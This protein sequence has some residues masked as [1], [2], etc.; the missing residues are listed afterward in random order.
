MMAKK[1][2]VHII[3][4]LDLGGAETALYRMLSTMSPN[5]EFQVIV[6]HG[7]GGYY[8][9]KITALGITV[10]HLNL[11]KNNI[12]KSFYRLTSLIKATQ[13]DLVQTWLYHADLIGGLSAKLCG[14]K[15]I[16]W[17]I[18][19]EG[20]G[21]KKT[22]ML[23][24]KIC[25]LFSWVIPDVIITNSQAA[26]YNHVRTGYNTK[27]IKLIYNGFDSV[28]FLPAKNKTSLI[29]NKKLPTDAI[30][31][32]TL[33]RFHQDK[34][35]LTLIQAIDP[36]CSVHNNVYF[37]FCGRGCNWHNHELT[38]MIAA[39]T[40]QKNIILIDG[41]DNAAHYLSSLDI[42]VLSSKTESFPNSLAEAML[43]GLLCIA[44]NVGEA[45]EILGNAGILIS[46]Q[47]PSQLAAACISMMQKSANE[48]EQLAKMARNRI[49]E[50]YSLENNQMHFKAIYEFNS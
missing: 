10:H 11:K 3:N 15:K 50:R 18:R 40:Y 23:I 44:T 25:A 31:I 26:T 27:K 32:G 48:K 49:V 17:S 43:S 28:Q 42:F 14:I 45:R 34:D 21:L 16:I 5:Y 33:A 2:V 9:A 46:P 7:S 35:Y 30:I 20:V 37:V 1:I 13:P 41:V 36:V 38:T 8:A 19:C 39:L 12:I 22:T 6:L 24:K 47:A 29:V 4:S